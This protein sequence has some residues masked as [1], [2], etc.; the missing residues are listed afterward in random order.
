MSEMKT[1]EHYGKGDP[2]LQSGQVVRLSLS[3]VGKSPRALYLG[4]G[5]RGR[6]SST[7]QRASLFIPHSQSLTSHDDY[8]KTCEWQD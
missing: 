3:E 2:I 8:V 1:R 5:S 4:L 6:A 7:S